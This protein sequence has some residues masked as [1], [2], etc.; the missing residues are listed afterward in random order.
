MISISN[1]RASFSNPGIKDFLTGVILTDRLFW[2]LL[3]R[4][5]TFE[6]IDAAW[7]FYYPLRAQLGANGEQAAEWLAALHRVYSGDDVSV[8]RVVSLAVQVA[9]EF[10]DNDEELLQFVSILM[11]RLRATPAHASDDTYFRHALEHR[12][13]MSESKRERIQDLDA[14]AETAAGLLAEQGATLGLSDIRMLAGA[15][16][17]YGERPDLG[18]TAAN[19]SMDDWLTYSFEEAVDEATSVQELEEIYSE[20]SKLTDSLGLELGATHIAAIDAKRRQLLEDEDSRESEGYQ[21]SRWKAPEP[22]F[23]DEQ[24]R[25][26]F[27]TILD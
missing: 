17:E 1:R 5:S 18:L 26:L 27:S 8:I 12:S 25:S 13:L 24:V 19:A 20:L 6:E 23:S 22:E 21:T 3:S 15:L 2:P 4:F 9:S 10:D 14:I 7:S 16:D 11:Q